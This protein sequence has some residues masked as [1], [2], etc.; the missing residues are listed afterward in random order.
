MSGGYVYIESNAHSREKAI[1]L[2]N[3]SEYWGVQDG[4]PSLVEIRGPL[5]VAPQWKIVQDGAVVAEAGFNITLAQ[6][7]RLLVSSYPEDMYARVYNADNTYS[8]VSA[9]ADFSKANYVRVPQGISTFLASLDFD[10]T[11]DVIFKEERLLV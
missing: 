9:Y 7:Q 4:S 6:T 10:T 11:L 1:T 2:H 8:D 5:N 3:D